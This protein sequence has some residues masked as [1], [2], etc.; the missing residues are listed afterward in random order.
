MSNKILLHKDKH[1]INNEIN[2]IKQTINI[3]NPLYERFKELE[4]SEM[5]P[6]E[7]TEFI[8]HPKTFFVKILSQGKSLKI[9]KLELNPEKVYELFPLP[10]GVKELVE[11]LERLI[12]NN[13]FLSYNAFNI[14]HISISE[15]ELIVSEN[16]VERITNKHTFYAETENQL[17][18]LEVL[19]RIANDLTELQS[20]KKKQFINPR[21]WLQE[22]FK[23]KEEKGRK[24]YT[25]NL[26]KVK[27]F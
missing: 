6:E 24:E 23:E 2:A 11:D 4:I 9:G 18:A 14:Q 13:D 1:K 7:F 25:V 15:N 20:L 26:M 12:K 16:Y 22:V 17:K 27:H 19:N 5:Q 21:E 3:L 8:N 10:T